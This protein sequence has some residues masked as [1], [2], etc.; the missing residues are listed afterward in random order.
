MKCHGVHRQNTF[1][2]NLF[3]LGFD[4]SGHNNVQTNDGMFGHLKCHET[5]T[6]ISKY[7][8]YYEK[9]EQYIG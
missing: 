2:H 7:T 9:E 4:M 5:Q 3:R 6:H 1:N 8:T